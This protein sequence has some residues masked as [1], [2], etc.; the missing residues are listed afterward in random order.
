MVNSQ[1]YTRTA[2]K[3]FY[4]SEDSHR[5]FLKILAKDVVQLTEK[6]NHIKNSRMWKIY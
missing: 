2:E 5:T 6:F 1:L 4:T 3:Y